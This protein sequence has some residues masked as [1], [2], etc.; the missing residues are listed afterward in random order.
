[1][2]SPTL[3]F[4]PPI[5]NKSV[6]TN[7][8]RC[9]YLYAGLIDEL[10]YGAFIQ[11]KRLSLCFLR[12]HVSLRG[13]PSAPR[14]PK[15]TIIPL[16]VP[17]LQILAEWYAL[18][19]GFSYPVSTFFHYAVLSISLTQTSPMGSFPV[20]PPWIIRYG[21]KYPITCPYREPGEVPPQFLITHMALSVIE[22]ISN[23]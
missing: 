10:L 8:V 16:A 20:F 18:G 22:N 6:P 5:T 23:W 13:S 9:W 19:G 15:I 14:P 4:R 21:F 3:L 1:M 17:V 7:N 11:S 2:H 12:P